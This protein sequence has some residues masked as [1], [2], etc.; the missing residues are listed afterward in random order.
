M[1]LGAVAPLRPAS[2]RRSDAVTIT[3][4]FLTWIV[5][6]AQVLIIASDGVW[7]FIEPEEACAMAKSF[8]PDAHAACKALV[9]TASQR[10][11]EV[12]TRA[13][14]MLVSCA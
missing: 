1:Y 7:D 4:R 6:H 13:R 5:T 3:S 12:R 11:I 8:V 9:E 14:S 2:A 10:W